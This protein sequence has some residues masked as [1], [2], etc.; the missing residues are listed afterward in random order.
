MK[1]LIGNLSNGKEA[2]FLIKEKE[3]SYKLTSL[4]DIKN[5]KN[6][7]TSSLSLGDCEE[8]LR[9]VYE[10]DKNQSLIIFQVDYYVLLYKYYFYLFE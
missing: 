7:N 9:K 3:I 10:I 8:T 4:K 5:N 6:L 1:S 2:E